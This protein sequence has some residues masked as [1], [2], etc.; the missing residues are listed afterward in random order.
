MELKFELTNYE[1]ADEILYRIY[2]H[3]PGDQIMD[4]VYY[5]NNIK[6]I[7]DK[8]YYN[9]IHEGDHNK[10]IQIYFY[11]IE[12][13][14]IYRDI[15]PEFEELVRIIE[16]RINYI[17]EKNRE[18]RGLFNL[19]SKPKYKEDLFSFTINFANGCVYFIEAKGGMFIYK[20]PEID[21][22]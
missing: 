12:K 9:L 1:P 11:G 21:K 22:G 13:I 8:L 16:L 4:E 3:L 18:N 15:D 20:E 10:K 17:K 19:V 2:P 5:L 7:E 14:S 6:I